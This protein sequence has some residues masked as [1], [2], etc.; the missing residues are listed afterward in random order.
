MPRRTEA[1]TKHLLAA[2]RRR[3]RTWLDQA[4][5]PFAVH[6]SMVDSSRGDSST[7]SAGLVSSRS[8]K[9]MTARDR[10]ELRREERRAR[11][12]RQGTGAGCAS[13][14]GLHGKKEGARVSRLGSTL[15]LAHRK[16]GTAQII[17]RALKKG[18]LVAV[19]QSLRICRADWPTGSLS[20][21][22]SATGG[23]HDLL[24]ARP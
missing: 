22:R 15:A 17:L 13:D 10:V 14:F 9:L 16:E 21:V 19:Y 23:A 2:R 6:K 20:L 4:S 24:L 7:S 8:P 3:A 5:Q 18:L 11:R 1:R 12:M